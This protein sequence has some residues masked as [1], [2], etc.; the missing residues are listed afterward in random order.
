VSLVYFDSLVFTS[1]FTNYF[2]NYSP[3]YLHIT[4]LQTT[5]NTDMHRQQSFT[6][7]SSVISRRRRRRKRCSW[8]IC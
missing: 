1:L 6:I 4:Q 3:I 5:S 7:Y 2:T 8:C